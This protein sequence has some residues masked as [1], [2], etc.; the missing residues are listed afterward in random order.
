MV[1]LL[2]VTLATG[3]W[4]RK[5]DLVE[6]VKRGEP[7]VVQVLLTGTID[8]NERDGSGATA[9]HWAARQDDQVTAAILIQAG[10]KVNVVDDHGIT[11]IALASINGSATMVETLLSAGADPNVARTTGETPLMSAAR[12]GRVEA[13]KLL[14]DGGADVN[15][16]ERWKGQTALMWAVAERHVEVAE[17]LVSVGAD[18]NARSAEGFSAVLF[19][20]QQ[21][22]V[23]TLR[24]LLDAGVD[25]NG[26]ANDGSTL[27]QVAVDSGTRAL[28]EPQ[29]APDDHHAE[30]IRFLLEQGADPNTNGAGRTPLHSAVWTAQPVVAEDLLAFGADPNARLVE[31]LPRLGRTLGGALK[32]T[33][34]GASPFWLAAHFADVEMMKLLVEHGANP[35][36]TSEDG[37]TPV[38]M[39]AGLHNFEGWDRYR[40]PWR[41]QREALLDRYLAATTLTLEL[42]GDVNAVNAAGLTALHGAAYAG[43]NDLV[44]L[45]VKHDAEIDAQ[46]NSGRTPLE[47]TT[48]IF[49]G[50]IFPNHE[51]TAQL[52]LELGADPALGT[53]AQS[54]RDTRTR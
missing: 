20:A 13:V 35:A 6:A 34:V 42:G 11:P 16:V 46:D 24:L 18:L 52:L 22:D 14:L 47:I 3:V 51:H 12:T 21:G 19:S 2:V 53:N 8:V 45:L 4:A 1:S 43:S 7:A 9:V 33:M 5:V 36:L 48:T 49:P 29:K 39:A 32:I 23:A 37:S 25:V 31:P 44:E 41:G 54:D 26:A 28:F 38:M 10:A 17:L 27:L 50:G 40:R 30:A 15:A